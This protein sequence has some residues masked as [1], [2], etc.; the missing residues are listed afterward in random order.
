MALDDLIE[1]IEYMSKS[2]QLKAAE[3][4]R[5]ELIVLKNA[6]SSASGDGVSATKDLN[7]LNEL[8]KILKQEIAEEG[9]CLVR[10]WQ[11]RLDRW[12]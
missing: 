9:S 10:N 7:A 3:K 4:K 11:V 6:V 1:E 5:F 2:D 8:I 12:Y